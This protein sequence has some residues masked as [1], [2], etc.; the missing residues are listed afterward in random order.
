MAG[1]PAKQESSGREKLKESLKQ[2]LFSY[3]NHHS[4]STS[5][6]TG[7]TA[8]FIIRRFMHDFTFL[9]ANVSIALTSTFVIPG[10]GT[11]PI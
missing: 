7:T 5:D 10:S 1:Q 9:Y 11:E 3:V 6:Q 8:D 4:T 2:F